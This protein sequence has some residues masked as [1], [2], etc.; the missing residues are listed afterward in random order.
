MPPLNKLKSGAFTSAE[1]AKITHLETDYMNK[2][3]I[4]DDYCKKMI[5]DYIRK[6]G[7]AK[8]SQLEEFLLPKLSENL[9][10]Q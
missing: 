2:V 1:V 7:S 9:S 6:F 3:G 8:K 4:D 10:E 5:L